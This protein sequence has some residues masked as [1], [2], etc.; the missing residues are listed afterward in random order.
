MALYRE[1]VVALKAGREKWVN[2]NGTEEAN[3]KVM[4][5][6]TS[7]PNELAATVKMAAAILRLWQM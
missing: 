2:L 6:L 5:T 7:C 3:L 4:Q 1:E